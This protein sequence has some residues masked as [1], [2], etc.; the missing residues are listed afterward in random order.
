MDLRQALKQ[1]QDAAAARGGV[2]RL[3]GSSGRLVASFS[4]AAI[5]N[6]VRMFGRELLSTAAGREELNE[7]ARFYGLAQ[8]GVAPGKRNRFGRVGFTKRYG[9]PG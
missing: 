2:R 8:G 6:G 1:D 7:Q 4:E 3:Q 5:Q 9:K